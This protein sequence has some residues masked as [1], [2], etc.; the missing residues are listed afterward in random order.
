MTRGPG[1]D[2]RPNSDAAAGMA[3]PEPVAQG[4][5]GTSKLSRRAMLQSSGAVLAVAGAG[6]LLAMAPGIPRSDGPWSDGT[7]FDDDTGWV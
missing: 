5:G 1:R 6:S 7:F 3:A 2:T 4:A